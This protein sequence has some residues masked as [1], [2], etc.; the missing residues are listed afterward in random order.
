MPKGLQEFASS[1]IGLTP[2]LLPPFLN[3]L[4][5]NA[6]LVSRGIPYNSYVPYLLGKL[7]QFINNGKTLIACYLFVI[8]FRQEQKVGPVR[9]YP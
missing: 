2:R 1:N 3:N 7:Q 5:K 4:K 6:Q 8:I 9:M